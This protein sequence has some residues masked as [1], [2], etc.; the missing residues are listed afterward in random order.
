M[1]DQPKFQGVELVAVTLGFYQGAMVHPGK[2]FSFTGSKLPKWAKGPKEAEAALKPK[3][4]ANADTKPAQAQAA[5]KVK[6]A[7]ASA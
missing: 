5:V 2:S 1:S 3:K 4:P 6:A 7:A